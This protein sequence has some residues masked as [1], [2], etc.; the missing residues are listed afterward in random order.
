[1]TASP[2]RLRSKLGPELSRMLL[3]THSTIIR[4]EE[5]PSV[6]LEDGSSVLSRGG[7]SDPF[8]AE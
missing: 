2:G 5:P 8:D 6:E 4:A 7:L 1:M 3:W